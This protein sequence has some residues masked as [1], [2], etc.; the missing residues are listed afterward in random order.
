MEKN[1]KKAFRQRLLELLKNQKEEVRFTKSKIIEHKLLEA[2]EFRQAKVIMFY[3][4]FNGEVETLSIMKQA[5][6]LG[7]QVVLPMIIKE[8]KK[9]IPSPIDSFKED[10]IRGPY[11]ITQPKKDPDSSWND[12]LD[13]VV[14]PGVAFDKQNNRLGRGEGYYDRFLKV[15]PKETPTFGLAFDFQIVGCLPFVEEHDISVSHVLTN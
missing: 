1:S 9:I 11:G 10:L 2:Q 14:V 8:E 6:K 4:S 12:Q 3:S 7:K 13:L 5:Q 15:L